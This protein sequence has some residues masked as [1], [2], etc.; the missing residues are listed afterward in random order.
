MISLIRC[1]PDG[2]LGVN[3]HYYMIGD[4]M[5]DCPMC[6]VLKTVFSVHSVGTG[7]KAPCLV[8]RTRRFNRCACTDHQIDGDMQ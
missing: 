3:P 8:Q 1:S 5:F 4:V 2:C 6:S 7:R